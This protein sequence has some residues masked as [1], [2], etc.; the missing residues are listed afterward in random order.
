MP[1]VVPDP[2]KLKQLID[3]GLT[4]QEATS[5]LEKTNNSIEAALEMHFGS[6]QDPPASSSAMDMSLDTYIFSF[7][8]ILEFLLFL[9]V[10]QRLR[11]LLCVK[12]LLYLVRW[13][14]YLNGQH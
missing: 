2:I 9:L 13:Q 12:F 11:Q 3:M 6:A 14:N 4:T 1:L 8:I 10:L 5:V 7:L